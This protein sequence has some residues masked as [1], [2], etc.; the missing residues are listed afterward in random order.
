MII[1]YLPDCIAIS[2]FNYLSYFPIADKKPT[3][4]FFESV[5]RTGLRPTTDKC[6]LFLPNNWKTV[7]LFP[8]QRR[9]VPAALI[10]W[11][12]KDFSEGSRREP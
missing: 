1:L 9:W 3:G 7:I 12:R 2:Y 8:W 10:R 4:I 11:S 6:Q 5:L